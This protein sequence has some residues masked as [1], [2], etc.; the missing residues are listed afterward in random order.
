VKP[1][2]K[3]S[4]AVLLL[5]ALIAAGRCS[6]ARE[7][8]GLKD[9]TRILSYSL[10]TDEGAAAQTWTQ[11][12]AGFGALA[13][14]SVAEL[15]TTLL[16]NGTYTLRLNATDVSGQ[17]ASDTQAVIV[18]RQMK[19]GIFTLA[20]ND[21]SVPVAGI[22][23]S[24]IRSYDSRE[25]RSGDFGYGWQLALRSIRLEKSCNLGRFWDESYDG[26]SFLPKYALQERRVH[27]V[28]IT[29][30]DGKVFKF[31]GAITPSQQ[32]A[33][34]INV[35]TYTFSPIAPTLGKL[36]TLGSTSISLSGPSSSAFVPPDG[37]NPLMEVEAHN[38]NGTMFNPTVFRLTTQ[39]GL[40]FVIDQKKGLQ[41][42]TDLNGNTV[43]ITPNGII[44]STGKS[45]VF[46]RDAAGRI[47]KITDPSGNVM[48]YEYDAKGDL[49]T[50]T[51][52]ESHATQFTFDNRHNLLTI[53]DPRGIT[54]IRNEY[55]A[56]GRLTK[57]I[58][59]YGKEIVYT[60]NIAGRSEVIADR[61][62]NSTTYTYDDHGNVL[63]ITDAEGG[64]TVSTYD[65][66]DNELT[67]TKL[68]ADSEVLSA[69]TYVY[70]SYDNKLSET[71]ALGNK[72]EYTY[73]NRR[74]MLTVKDAE[75]N[76]TTNTYNIRANLQTVTDPMGGVTLY[77]YNYAF[78]P[79]GDPVGMTDALGNAW[80]YVYDN[81]GNRGGETDPYSHTTSSAFDASNS[82]LSQTTTRTVGGI[83]ETL[84]TSYVYD[85]S[86][87]PTKTTFA[88]GTYTT[89]IYNSIGKQAGTFDQLG[90][91]TKYEY[92]DAGRL[93]AT[94]FPDGTFEM[95]K[96][97]AEGRRLTSQDRAQRI[98]GYEYDKVGRLTKTTFP[99]GTFTTTKY[100]LAGQVTETTDEKGNVTKYRYDLAGRRTEV[101]D[102]LGKVTVLAYDKNGNQKTVTDANQH[103]TTYEYD[104]NNRRVKTIFH[105]Q[106]FTTTEYDK[107]GRRTAEGDQAGKRTEFA[108]DKLGRLTEVKD[109]AS[110]VTR[111]GYNE[112]G[113]QL[114][115]VDALSR[116][117]AYEYDKLGR[118]V[119]RTLPLGQIE[120]YGYDFGGNLT[121]RT[122]FNGRKTA[123]EYDTLNRLTKKTPDASF[124][125]PAVSFTYTANGQR[126]SMTDASGVVH[127]DYDLRERLIETA[128]PQGTLTYAYDEAGNL[129]RVA[130]SNGGVNSTYSYDALNRC[131]TVTSGAGMTTYTFDDEGNLQSVALPN[132]VATSYTYN[133]LN[134]LTNVASS[135]G[136]TVLASYGYTLG[137]AGNRTA[138]AELSGRT[139]AYGYD[140]LYRLVSETIAGTAQSGVIGYS[141]DAVGNRLGR[142]STVAA[143][144]A[145]TNTVDAND[146]L[147][148][149]SYDA[150]GN[151]TGSDGTVYVY[152]FENRI[153]R[154][155]KPDG[156]TI[157]IM[158]DGDG[159]RVAKS[160]NGVTTSYLVDT[161]NLT[162]YAQVVEEIQDGNVVCAYTYGLDLIA[163]TRAGAT[164]HYGYDGHGSVRYL[165]DSAGT[166]TD[167]YD[168]DA[169]GILIART[170]TT[171]N[172]Y[173]YA[174]EQWDEDVGMYYNRARYLQPQTGR[175]W[176]MDSYNGDRMDPA[177]LH[178]YLYTRNAP[179]NRV[180]P[181]GHVDW[182]LLGQAFVNTIR[183]TVQTIRLVAQFPNVAIAKA[184]SAAATFA[185]ANY[186]IAVAL[187]AMGLVLNYY[188]IP[189]SNYF[190][191]PFFLAEAALGLG[192][193][194]LGTVRRPQVAINRE[195]GLQGELQ[196]DQKLQR[197][198]NSGNIRIVARQI[199]AETEDGDR[200]MDFL[201]QN[202]HTGRYYQ[203]EGK[204]NLAEMKGTQALKDLHIA[205]GD[206]RFHGAE[207]ARRGLENS[208]V[209]P[210]ETIV[211]R[212][213]VEAPAQ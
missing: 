179:T 161:N 166:V 133:G 121:S 196:L 122:D 162:G 69:M 125:A 113:Q 154:V 150:N 171:P 61:L 99:D 29:F 55:D 186:D 87:R 54:P 111:Y 13:N 30:P 130:S 175:F 203:I 11:L 39:E 134:R 142:T 127:Y 132:G 14:Q 85:P 153:Q 59:S 167:T 209:G 23:I 117:T 9:S 65:D 48:F 19:V 42:M 160:V 93:M 74:Q 131:A 72:T 184:A 189:G 143:V 33:G 141:Y 56:N 194:D 182:S 44:S 173:R 191:I 172:N 92:D 107:L 109:A 102:T 188:N 88:D 35:G 159:N 151:T 4:A 183:G 152:D 170:G 98:T 213:R 76:V 24:V 174:G 136:G 53:I 124:N 15:D 26:T 80:Q 70:D 27:K 73:N 139:V 123:Y 137:P 158:Y 202:L 112:V 129:N 77:T 212:E 210:M 101:E 49:V 199:H 84:L 135:K 90:R 79:A 149:D 144:P 200:V 187:A 37:L 146:R 66:R 108:Y 168:Y 45:I 60:H 1:K 211:A 36:E 106:T 178:R 64:V 3:K 16:L 68:D 100:D 181:S 177:S 120:T 195:V 86:A 104:A 5:L 190:Y 147:A 78:N 97:D 204:A 89:V 103:V 207:A 62:G 22:P 10:N 115:Q 91:E 126:E 2:L 51:D 201:I 12:A 31:K 52:R 17:T 198:E 138:V 206:Y 50:F 40:V 6:P 140:N 75:G 43:T 94:I 148:S 34:P 20:F 119:K 118:R 95:S 155:T 28:T 164:T 71:D 67:Q 145:Q 163:Q 63:A 165:T 197:A 21:L 81:Y 47:T 25:K 176:T 180:D 185:M 157:S 7:V 205:S 83:V 8:S 128:T 82:L 156:T 18:E 116:T 208:N 193:P 192:V 58:D 38:Y 114:T 96:Y 46:N 169:F 105:D 32:S 110:Q 41:S 57:H